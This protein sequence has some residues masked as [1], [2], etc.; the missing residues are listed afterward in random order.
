MQQRNYKPLIVVLTIAINGLILL[1]FILPK[2]PVW[3]RY[4]F[5]VLPLLNAVLNGLTFLLLLA[6]LY[7]ALRK[8]IRLH[9]LFIFL[10]FSCTSLFLFAYLL[11]H[12]STPSTRYGGGGILRG[13]YFF[14]L[15]T[16][17]FLAAL[18]VPLALFTMAAGLNNQ[19]ERHRKI[20]RWTMPVWLYVSFTGVVVYLLISPYYPR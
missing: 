14:I 2:L 17:V 19:V 1:A 6:A 9:R 16:H 12:F 7:A 18:T 8:K 15:S 13:I 20:A 4:H 3:K 10:A 5:S 11:Y